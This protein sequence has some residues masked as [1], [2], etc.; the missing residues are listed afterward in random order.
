MPSSQKLACSPRLRALLDR[1]RQSINAGK[2]LS[3]EDF[4]KAV[5]ERDQDQDE[6]EE[7]RP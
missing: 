6:K 4:W 1:S 3:Q 2:G 7:V 5:A